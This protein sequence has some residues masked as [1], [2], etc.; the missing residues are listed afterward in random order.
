M[1][2]ISETLNTKITERYDGIVARGGIAG[3][4]GALAAARQGSKTL[5]IENSY[6][7]GGLATSGLVTIYLPLCDGFG[8]QISFGICEELIRLSTKYG[9]EGRYNKAWFEKGSHDE[10]KKSRFQV[11]FNPH[12]F[13]ME[14]EKLLLESK[15]TILYGT[16]LCN[17]I[18]PN[19]ELT[20]VIVEN[21]SGRQAFSCGAAV[22]CTGDADLFEYAKLSTKQ[23]EEQNILAAW[24][25]YFS[26]GSVG[27]RMLGFAETPE[28]DNDAAVPLTRRR[29][30]GLDAMDNSEMVQ[31]SHREM[32]T[33]IL[34]RRAQDDTYVPIT[35]PTIPQLRMTR[36]IVGKCTLSA[37]EKHKYC[38][39]S[40]GMISNWKKS[41]P[42]YEIPFEALFSSDCTNL[43]AAGRCISTTDEMW[44][45]SRVIPSCAVTGEAAGIAASLAAASKCVDIKTLQKKLAE[46]SV[47][48]HEKDL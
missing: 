28:D 17:A 10:K 29:F 41:G 1:T 35:M 34:G 8:R 4:S 20:H 18:K 40:I 7:L 14:A 11:Q 31:M 44:D 24:Y 6:I 37:E 48:L 12:F 39:T 46:N 42:V 27:L 2:H 45:I 26:K 25:Y 38:E 47:I 3:I 23:F 9:A 16:K 21:K 30:T 19:R 32:L 22:D 33:D 43:F 15:V 13:A 36:R 5:L